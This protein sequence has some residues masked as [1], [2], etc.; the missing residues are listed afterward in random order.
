ML[1]LTAIIVTV[2]GYAL[3]RYLHLRFPHGQLLLK[4]CLCV[5]VAWW[6]ISGDWDVYQSGGSWVALGLGPATVALAV[7]LA[8]QIRTMAQYWKGIMAGITV[9]CLVSICSAWITIVV[10]G[11][12]DVLL[13]SMLS[14]SVT[15]PFSIEL[16]ASIGGN[17]SLAAFFTAVT[18]LIGSMLYRPVLR[19][20][21][22]NDNWSIGIAVGTSSHAIGSAQLV[23]VSEEQAAAAS[24]AMILSGIV[25]SLYFIPLHYYF[26]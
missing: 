25:T 24:L 4:A 22:I 2:L 8:K 5:G 15:T 16:T 6:V 9:G 14:K 20:A 26:N 19:L 23:P 7:P 21:G 1:E 17:T 10:F 13:R 18:G 11:G 3:A 12:D